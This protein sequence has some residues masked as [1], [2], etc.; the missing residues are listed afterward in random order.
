MLDSAVCGHNQLKNPGLEKH[1][2]AS[3]LCRTCFATFLA[4]L[5]P[6]PLPFSP[7]SVAK[8]VFLSFPP[9]SVAKWRFYICQFLWL[10]PGRFPKVKGL[11]FSHPGCYH[12]R[13]TCLVGCSAPYVSLPPPHLRARRDRARRARR[14]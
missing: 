3:T 8:W 9:T 6:K 10:A 4:C 14:R 5:L 12:S 7:T 11:S 2:A 13:F 1:P